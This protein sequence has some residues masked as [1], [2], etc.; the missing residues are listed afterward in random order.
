MRLDKI[1]TKVGDKG[2]TLLATGNKVSKGSARIEAYGT[3][4]ELNAHVGLLLDLLMQNSF[5]GSLEISSSLKLI[6]HELFDIGGELA[7]PFKALD[8]NKQQVVSEEHVRRL[9]SQIDLFNQ[10]LKPLQNFILPGGHLL[11]SQSHIC[12][13]VCRRAERA[14]VTLSEL[15]QVRECAL[16]YLNRLSDWFFVVSRLFSSRL[17]CPEIL[18]Q[19]NKDRT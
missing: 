13:C 16:I 1:Y 11:N 8:I 9:E 6:Q 14:T 15:E 5:E 4:D 2:R 12:R 17:S 19:Q 7:T 10:G 18:W 3:V